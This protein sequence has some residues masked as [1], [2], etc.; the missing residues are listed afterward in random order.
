MANPFACIGAA[1]NVELDLAWLRMH[2][3][4][5][6]RPWARIRVATHT[7]SAPA[8]FFL[9]LSCD[10]SRMLVEKRYRNGSMKDAEAESKFARELSTA[11]QLAILRFMPATE[12]ERRPDGAFQDRAQGIQLFSDFAPGGSLSEWVETAARSAGMPD[13]GRSLKFGEIP[14]KEDTVRAYPCYA[15]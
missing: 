12:V 13:G 4:A 3:R 5:D 15:P 14:I 8:D 6:A 10:G 9:L 1:G 7:G 11:R 2:D